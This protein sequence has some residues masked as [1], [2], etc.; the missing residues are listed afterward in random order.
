MDKVSPDMAVV[1]I[2][3]EQRRD[4][5]FEVAILGRGEG[6]GIETTDLPQQNRCQ[7]NSQL[8]RSGFRI[9]GAR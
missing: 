5:S 2:V 4:L 1:E 6:S 3:L 8:N 7:S 9:P